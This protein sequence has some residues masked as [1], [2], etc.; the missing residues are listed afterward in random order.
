MLCWGLPFIGQSCRV[1]QMPHQS[2]FSLRV[3]KNIAKIKISVEF[4]VSS[5]SSLRNLFAWSICP[6]KNHEALCLRQVE[7]LNGGGA[8]NFGSGPANLFLGSPQNLVV[9]PFCRFP[10]SFSTWF[11][12]SGAHEWLR[13]CRA[14][15][16]SGS[17]LVA[18][19]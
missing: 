3:P 11:R 15:K 5:D 7:P 4:R 8:A 1:F 9:P 16:I 13:L 17:A 10:C 19:H 12:I 18:P 6:P 2:D 14:T